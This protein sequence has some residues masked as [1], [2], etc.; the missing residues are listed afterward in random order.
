MQLKSSHLMAGI[1]ALAVTGWMLSG[2]FL[3]TSGES[4]APAANTT[5]GSGQQTRSTNAAQSK[6]DERRF[7]VAALTVRNQQI[8]RTIRASGVSEAK[9][10]MTV[11]S[12]ADGEIIA[13]EAVEGRAVKA[14]ATLV[15]LEKA[16][17]L[18]RLRRLRPIWR[19][20]VSAGM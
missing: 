12:K 3:G 7:S 9:F 4:S 10:N 1:V 19:S 18:S 20:R 11:S 15:R 14:G 2:N 17:W 8:T 6:A 13:I 16:P 5:A